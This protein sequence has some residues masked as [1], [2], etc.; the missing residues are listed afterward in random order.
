MYRVKVSSA[1]IASLH[2]PDLDSLWLG[3]LARLAICDG[4]RFVVSCSGSLVASKEI[5]VPRGDMH[6]G[7][8]A[9][10]H[11]SSRKSVKYAP[12]KEP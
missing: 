1:E 7:A 5:V 6:V 11:L 9:S 4:V 2:V 12:M 10:E 8:K 3:V